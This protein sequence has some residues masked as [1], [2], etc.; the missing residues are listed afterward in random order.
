MAKRLITLLSLCLALQ[1]A[2]KPAPQFQGETLDGKRVSLKQSLRPGR[3]L[4]LCFWASWCTPCLQELKEVSTRLKNDPSLPLDMLAI[5]VDT[6]ETASDVGP[7]LKL[8]GFDFPVVMDQ[9]HTIFS[10]YQGAKSLP[11]SALI[12]P[13]GEISKTFSGFDE[14]MFEEVKK[15]LSPKT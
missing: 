13:E 6:S 8:Y 3:S 7:T 11:F 10:K 14:Q 4:I 2:A 1:L 15:H 5:N 12:S 9:K